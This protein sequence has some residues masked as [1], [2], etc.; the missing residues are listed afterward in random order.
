MQ[1]KRSK[2]L[3]SENYL[4]EVGSKTFVPGFED[5]LIGLKKGET[6]AIT[7]KFPDDYNA[8]HLAGKDVEFKVNIKGIRIKKMPEIDDNFIKNF[9][10]YESLDA[11]KADVRKGLEEEKKRKIAAE[12]ER[13]IR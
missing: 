4:L 12:F 8:S 11:L 3:T 1:E 10:K 6:K 5:Q 7:V 9:D 2:S 13:G